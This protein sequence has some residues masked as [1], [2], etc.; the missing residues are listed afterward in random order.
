MKHIT[1]LLTA[2]FL[3]ISAPV[4]N[5]QKITKEKLKS[6]NKERAYYLFVPDGLDRSKP[7][8]LLVMLHGAGRT[9]EMLVEKW[10]DLAKKEGIVLVG[11]DASGSQWNVPDDAPEPIYDLVEYLK[12]K[13]P[14]NPRRV[15][16]FGHSAG[17]VL[18][19]GA[20]ALS[21]WVLHS[22]E[23]IHRP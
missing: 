8:P 22:G 17:A 20:A 6:Q 2:F 9:V 4:T 11:P 5:G 18:S 13:Y 15:Y 3:F 14:I 19:L 7:A 1:L 21:F 10:K 16:L 12:T 23:C